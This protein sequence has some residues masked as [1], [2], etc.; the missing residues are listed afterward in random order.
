MAIRP[1]SSI[2]DQCPTS[3][4]TCTVRGLF[5]RSVT[6]TRPCGYLPVSWDRVG[7]PGLE[8]WKVCRNHKGLFHQDLWKEGKALRVVAEGVGSVVFPS[9]SR[10]PLMQGLGDNWTFWKARSLIPSCTQI[11]DRLGRQHETSPLEWSGLMRDSPNIYHRSFSI[12]DVLST[13]YEKPSLK[14]RHSKIVLRSP[15]FEINLQYISL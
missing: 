7:A 3:Y 5:T 1:D 2:N 11:D 9:A 13:A 10:L 4:S 12:V 8:Q 6:F 14:A 15:E